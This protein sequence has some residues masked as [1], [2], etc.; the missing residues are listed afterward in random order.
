MIQCSQDQWDVY[1]LDPLYACFVR[2]HPQPTQITRVTQAES[3]PQNSQRKRRASTSPERSAPPPSRRK[4]HSDPDE[5]L[6]DA[7]DENMSTIDEMIVDPLPRSDT[8][9]GFRQ[10]SM[11]REQRENSRRAAPLGREFFSH[12]AEPSNDFLPLDTRVVRKRKR[13]LN[14]HGW[15][16]SAAIL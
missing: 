14:Y 3:A 2:T 1:K 6:D 8:K 12:T 10:T 16:I 15:M 4:L 7:T 9:L 11:P 5:D 13:M